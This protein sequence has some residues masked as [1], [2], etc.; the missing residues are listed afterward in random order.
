M[1]MD[2]IDVTLATMVMFP[3]DYRTSFQSL[4]VEAVPYSSVFQGYKSIFTNPDIEV[5]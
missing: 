2:I 1:D 4:I 5:R 3:P